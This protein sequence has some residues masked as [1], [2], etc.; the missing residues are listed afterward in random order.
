MPVSIRGSRIVLWAAAGAVAGV[1]ASAPAA[2]ARS[3]NVTPTSSC[4]LRL[5]IAA[6]NSQTTQGSCLP[7]D[8]NND[9]I[10]LASGI[11]TNTTSLVISRNMVLDG[12]GIGST[13]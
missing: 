12:A 13:I 6:I 8:G 11:Y 2:W 10:F 4:S 7:G 9:T 1:L 5:A 3:Y